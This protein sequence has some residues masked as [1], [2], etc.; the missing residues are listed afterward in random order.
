MIETKS[1]AAPHLRPLWQDISPPGPACVALDEPSGTGVAIIGGGFLGLSVA[2][3]LAERG[4]RCAVLEAEEV[5]AGASGRNTGFVVPSIRVSATPDVLASRHGTECAG[6]FFDLVARSGDITFDLIN[7]LDLNCNAEQSGWMQPAHSPKAMKAVK[8]A[9][10]RAREKGRPVRFL[11]AAEAGAMAGFPLPNGALLDNSGGQLNPLAYVR[12]LAG[13]A[14]AAGATVYE[15]TTVTGFA[16][17]G[18]GWRIDTA[19]SSLRAERILLT[20]NA[21]TGALHRGFAASLAPVRVFQIA[22]APLPENAAVLSGG[23]SLSDTRRHTFAL[24]RAPGGGLVTGGL[25][26]AGRAEAARAVKKFSRRLATIA[27]ISDAPNTHVWSGIIALTQDG[28][29]RLSTLEPGLDAAVSCNGRGVALTTALGAEIAAY[30]SGED[31]LAL[32]LA[33]LTQHPARRLTTHGASLSLPFLEAR[34]WWES[35]AA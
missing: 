31:A 30:L 8:S 33:P 27:R 11:E 13:A 14:A 7:R 28:L 12:A 19:R 6:A 3:R 18:D 29:P 15:N 20:T 1:S 35:R 9:A 17:A 26:R 25:V 5:G 4:V 24:R 23:Q 16:R 2:L 10:E 22:T 34:D 32:P 21:L